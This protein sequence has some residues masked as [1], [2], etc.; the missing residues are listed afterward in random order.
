MITEPRDLL[1]YAVE[2]APFG[3]GQEDILVRF[4]LTIDEYHRRISEIIDSPV[5]DTLAVHIRN[6]IR[7]QCSTRRDPRRFRV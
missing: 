4:G 7:R 1:E 6:T 5:A 3:G 2:W